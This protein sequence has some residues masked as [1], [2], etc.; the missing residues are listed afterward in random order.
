MYENLTKYLLEFPGDE[1][2]MWIINKENDG[3]PEHPVQMSYVNYS[4]LA[5]SF[6][7][8]VYSFVEA[9]EEMELNRYS[10]ILEA[11]GIKWRRDSMSAVSVENLDAK[12]VLALILLFGVG[13]AISPSVRELVN[14][15]KHDV[16]KVDD[17]TNYKTIK[18]VEDTCRA[19]ISSYE[20]DKLSYE[21]YK[22]S[23][24]KEKT[25]WAEQ[26]KMRANKTAASYNNYILK[27][28]YVWSGN[29][30]KDIYTKLEYIKGE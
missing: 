6:T 5:R 18:K 13:Y 1:K 27:N 11:N 3:T 21:Q 24:N 23:T 19:M 16:Q 10:D 7:A 25:E 4:K 29:V 28:N 12:C 17:R 8:D 26:A 14:G 22:N 15:V 2:G 30:P 9:H 20:A